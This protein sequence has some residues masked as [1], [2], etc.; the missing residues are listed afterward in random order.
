MIVVNLEYFFW[1]FRKGCLRVFCCWGELN[2][3]WAFLVYRCLGLIFFVEFLRI[4][5]I[6]FFSCFIIIW[7]GC[8]GILFKIGSYRWCRF[9]DG[10]KIFFFCKFFKERVWLDFGYL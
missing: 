9:V 6:F 3:L 8:F 4:S 5:R 1:N 2:V 7:F 10:W